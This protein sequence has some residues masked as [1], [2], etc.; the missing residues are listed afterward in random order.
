MDIYGII[1]LVVVILNTTLGILI[2][3]KGRKNV[4]NISFSIYA[5]FLAI[6]PLTLFLFRITDFGIAIFWMKSAYAAAVFIAASFWYFSLV[7]PERKTMSIVDKLLTYIP[8]LIV[9]IFLYWPSF[10]TKELTYNSW[11]KGVVL[12]FWEYILFSVYFVIYYFGGCVRLLFKYLHSKGVHK[13]QLL[14][15]LLSILFTGTFGVYFNLI[16]P[17]P[18]FENHRYIWLGPVFTGFVLLGIFYTIV[19]YRL[20]DIKLV[21]TRSILYFFVVGFV[22]GIYTLMTLLLGRYF[23]DILNFNVILITL[24]VSTFIVLTLDPLKHAMSYI[25]DN[26]FYKARIDYQVVLRRAVNTLNTE[27]ELQPLVKKLTDT[28]Q[29]EL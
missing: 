11:G 29:K 19:R 2:Y 24:A 17:S 3:L 25:T 4:I 28:V 10:L 9:V 8:A 18:F 21:I 20:M 6:W 15:V 22:A 27:L 1:L 12:G 7:F 26:I 14:Y 13:T 23:Q 16:L 5:I